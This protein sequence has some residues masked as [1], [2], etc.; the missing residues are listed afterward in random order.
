MWRCCVDIVKFILFFTNLIACLGFLSAAGF[1]VYA[2]FNGEDTFLGKHIEPSLSSSN[3]TALLFTFIII[4]LVLLAFFSILTCLGCCG[5]AVK[6]SCMIGC[7]IVIEFVMFG[8]SVGGIIYLHYQ[9][10]NPVLNITQE[11]LSRSV[12]LYGD[13]S[14]VVTALW[15]SLIQ[16]AECCKIGEEGWRPWASAKLPDN[17]KVPSVCCAFQDTE[18]MYEP[19]LDNTFTRDCVDYTLPIFTVLFY[20]IPSLLLL[21]L[22]FAFIVTSSFEEQRGRKFE[23]QYTTTSDYSIGADDDFHHEPGAPPPSHLQESY[24]HTT[25]TARYENPPYN[26]DYNGFE[27]ELNNYSRVENYPVGTIPP[28]DHSK[29][30]L[31]KP[32][33]YQEAVRYS[34][35]R[36]SYRQQDSY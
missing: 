35:V 13:D 1:V 6:S 31:N 3:P 27:V 24:H 33:S 12:H 20:G 14:V 30:L 4:A 9:Y 17:Y 5:T 32:P 11:G 26:P 19:S 7:F 29:P 28:P 8:G 15:N 34:D 23:R 36:L 16:F 2:L 18:C 21:S 25:T 10:S 22:I